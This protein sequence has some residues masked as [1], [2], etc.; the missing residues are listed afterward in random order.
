[1]IDADIRTCD[2]RL[3]ALESALVAAGQAERG[4]EEAIAIFTPRRNIETWIAYLDGHDVD[5]VS[6]YP[7]L[8]RERECRGRVEVLKELC[9]QQALRLPAPDSLHR[10]CAEYE[11]RLPKD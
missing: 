1:M 9:D 11:Q 8:D 5:E 7:K 3:D 10:A 2:E 4:P 6:A